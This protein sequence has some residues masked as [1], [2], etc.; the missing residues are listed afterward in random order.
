MT[1]PSEPTPAA[2]SLLAAVGL[3]LGYRNAPAVLTDVSLA[4]TPGRVLVIAGPNAAGKTTLLRGLLGQLTPRSGTVTL[5]G[6]PIAAWPAA[7]RA[8]RLAYIPRQPDIALGFA[9]IDFVAMARPGTSRAAA[10]AA[11]GAVDLA[12]RADRR[13]DELSAGQQQRAAW[14]RALLQINALP[15]AHAADVTTPAVLLGDE[16]TSALDP[17]HALAAHALT[18]ELA[19]RGVAVGLVMHDLAAARRIA[20]DALVLDAGGRIAAAGPVE[21][22]LV[23]DVLRRVFRVRYAEMPL[24]D[25]HT[26]TVLA[27]LARTPPAECLPYDE[28]RTESP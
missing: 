1:P 7:E 4:L 5:A 20:D 23:P 8:R 3:T 22:T 17:E 27:P 16:P 11:L 21:D 14:A 9:A 19:S 24:P 6:K 2:S 12:N 25:P 26:G 10:L 13:F 18:R 28:T 15:D